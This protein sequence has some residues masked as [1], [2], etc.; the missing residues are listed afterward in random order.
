[1][2]RKVQC[3]KGT[4]QPDIQVD[5]GFAVDKGGFVFFHI[6]YL[7]VVCPQRKVTAHGFPR[8][9]G[10]VTVHFQAFFV[11]CRYSEVFQVY[12]PL[13]NRYDGGIEGKAGAQHDYFRPGF[14]E[15]QSTINKKGVK[16]A[17]QIQ[18]SMQ[19]AMQKCQVIGYECADYSQ[20]QGGYFRM[21]SHGPVGVTRCK[22]SVR[23]YSFYA[24][25]LKEGIHGVACG[26]LFQD[27]FQV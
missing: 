26:F 9:E 10:Y 6:D 12:F 22:I 5:V 8:Q 4:V 27:V 20:R 17:C 7:E 3:L 23:Q 14:P 24:I 1:M 2:A 13:A 21:K 15:S 11:G 16:G 19:V 18:V 25:Q